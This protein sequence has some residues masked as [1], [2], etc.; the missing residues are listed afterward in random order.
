MNKNKS[1]PLR[2]SDILKAL[3]LSIC[4]TI[5]DCTKFSNMSTV[6]AFCGQVS[7]AL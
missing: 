5:Q 4:D 7:Q 1:R 3:E 6:G 2:N